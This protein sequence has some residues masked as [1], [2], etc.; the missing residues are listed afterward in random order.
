MGSFQKDIQRANPYGGVGRNDM[1]EEEE[2]VANSK[3]L[4]YF[5]KYICT[6]YSKLYFKN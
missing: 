3:F 6:K 1:D 2:E 5:L 4:S